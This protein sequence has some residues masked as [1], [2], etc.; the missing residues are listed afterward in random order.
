MQVE[1]TYD[2]EGKLV[3]RKE[4]TTP[5]EF[6]NNVHPFANAMTEWYV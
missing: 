5:D 6:V 3:A 1:H 2:A 4:K